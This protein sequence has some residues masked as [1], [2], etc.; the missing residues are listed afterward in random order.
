[1]LDPRIKNQ[2]PAPKLGGLD[3]RKAAGPDNKN[4]SILKPSAKV[5]VPYPA[6]FFNLSL[7]TAKINGSCRVTE[8]LPIHAANVGEAIVKYHPVCLLSVVL[9]IMERCTG[10]RSV[11]FQ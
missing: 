6:D 5:I 7:T 3:V 8:V 1:M 9:K 10:M 2:G 4:P 11:D